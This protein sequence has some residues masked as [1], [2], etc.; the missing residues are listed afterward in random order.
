MR[1][2][3]SARPFRAPVG[4]DDRYSKHGQS[5]AEVALIGRRDDLTREVRHQ[6]AHTGDL[7]DLH[8]VSTST[9]ADHHLDRVELLGDQPRSALASVTWLVASGPDLDL[10]LAPLVAG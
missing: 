7:A 10:L 8:D 3:V 4:G 1:S 9:R 5:L 2:A 6:A